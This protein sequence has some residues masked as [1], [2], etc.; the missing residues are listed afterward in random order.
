MAKYIPGDTYCMKN[1][2]RS[3]FVYFVRYVERV[4]QSDNITNVQD[5][6]FAKKRLQ[7]L[8]NPIVEIKMEA[9][10]PIWG[11]SDPYTLMS[12]N[13]VMTSQWT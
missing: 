2:H 8:S 4:C 11:W 6:E 12:N 9:E 5:A 13:V 3:K 10:F 7:N 1:C